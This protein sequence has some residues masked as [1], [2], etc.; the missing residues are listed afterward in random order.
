M[1]SELLPLESP[2]KTKRLNILTPTEIDDLFVQPELSEDERTWLFELNP[3][4]QKILASTISNAAKVDAIIRLGYFKRKQQFFQF[5]LH[6]IPDDVKHVSERYLI[7]AALDRPTVGR[8]VK[9]SNQQ[10]VLRIM[11]YTM[12]SQAEHATQLLNKAEKLCRLSVNPLFLFRELLTELTQKRITRPGYSTFQKIVSSALVSEQKRI[13]Q[14]FKEHLKPTEKEQL[15]KLL[16]HEENFYAVTLLKQQPKNFKPTAIRQE[17][18]YYEQ[19]QHLYQIAKR[20][21]PLLGVSKNGVTYYASLVEHYTVWSLNRR[22]SDQSCLWLLCFIYHRCQRMLDNLA[23]MFIYTANQYQDEVTIQA[24][25]LLLTHSLSP[26]EKK[27]ALAKLIRV[28]TNKDLDEEQSFKTIK[29]FVYATI[30]PAERIN[31]VADELD[32]QEQ[33]KMH[34]TQ[35][36]WQAVDEFASTYQPLL[37]ALVKVLALD[38]QQHKA[39][40]KAYH[41]LRESFKQNQPLSK[42]PFDKFPL[43]FINS[44]IRDFIYDIGQK[45]IHIARYEYECYQ[46]IANY[47][48]GRSLFL[49]DSINY[50]SLSAELIPDWKKVKSTVLKKV[51]KPLLNLPLSR[52]IEE[53]AKPL[54]EKIMAINGAIANGENHYVKLK[55]DKDGSTIWTLPYTKK[56]MD[57]NNPFYEK[58]PPIGISRIM[59]FVN[60]KT[61]FM[62]QFTHIKPSYAKSQLDEIAIHACVIANG[63]NL[64]IFKMASLSDLNF[65]SLQTTEKNY[66][67]LATLRAANDIIS[68]AIAKLPI[69]RHWNLQQ[70]LLHAS[71]DGQ[72][73]ITEWDN[74]LARYSQKYFGSLQQGVVAYSLIANHIP[75][76]T[77][78]IGAN[79]HESRFFFDLIYNNTSEIQPDLFST[80]TEGSNK[81]NFLLLHLIGRIY[82]P[83]YRSLRDKTESIIC[84]SDPNK[85]KDGTIRPYRKLNEKLILAEEDN[86][87]HILASLLMG[88]TKQSNIIT[89]L[90]S[91]QFSSR[92]KQALWEMNAVLMSDHLLNYICDVTFRQSIQGALG[93]GEAYHQ[94][95]RHIE[96]VNGRHFRG[97]NET[98]IA[99]WNECARLL[100]NCVLYYNASMLNRWKEQSDRNGEVQKSEFIKQLSPAAWTHVNF[101]GRYE[102]LSPLETIDIDGWLDKILINESDFMKN[103]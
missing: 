57:L 44:K 80:D 53:K 73:F 62:K 5:D 54:D 99:V 27:S 52:F 46:Q 26:D 65:K 9:L 98:Q 82:A 22:N 60:E 17:I 91:Q 35:F 102:F 97:T 59:Q 95:R 29:E 70:D 92:T 38:S 50:Q 13:G 76:N 90:S 74:L 39:A 69:F 93:R 72:K 4:E 34:Q 48:N 83:R 75:I 101:Q 55:K 42:I 11:G 61:Q 78:I 21:L 8:A 47:L 15:F 1:M 37:R 16:D 36:V 64:G 18:A 68:N 28:Y 20:I 81:L 94:L 84:F 45:T 32:N 87:Q 58:L 86:I 51:N 85:F 63:T 40:Q 96:K 100:A 3:E 31:Q 103:G 23:T 71:L 19:Y 49:N 33:Q 56:S 30:L 77:M 41:F 7:P 89:K 24:Q 14:L 12:F 88:E 79:E 10:W 25:A 67:R 2:S 43:Q 66:L 6:E